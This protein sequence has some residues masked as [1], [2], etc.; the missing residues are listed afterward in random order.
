MDEIRRLVWEGA[1]NVQVTV[2]SSLLIGDADLRH[3]TLNLRLPRET[4][5]AIY[6][7]TIIDRLRNYLRTDP[8]N[9]DQF[10]W[11]ECQGVPVYWNYP[12]GI[13]YDFMTGLNPSDRQRSHC[14]GELLNVWKLE[15]AQGSQLPPGVIP[16]GSELQLVRTY[17]MQQWKQACYVLNGSSKQMMS[18]SMQDTQKFWDALIARDQNA[19]RQVASKII[20]AKPRSIPICIHQSLPKM[21]MFQPIVAG[22]KSDGSR[23]KLK[24]LMKEQFS[25]LFV[26]DNSLSKVVSNGIELPLTLDLLDVYARFMSLDGYLHLSLCLLSESEYGRAIAR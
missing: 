4:Y 20:P 15:L 22:H 12:I 25:S 14:S 18:L 10:V 3:Y 23:M 1:L 19:F 17:W 8:D 9:E 21:Q 7:R 13:L 6:L 5:I 11:L 2:K 24:D 26:D 16:F